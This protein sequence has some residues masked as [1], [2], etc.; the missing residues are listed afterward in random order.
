MKV[1]SRNCSHY[2]SI[3][4][5]HDKGKA[6]YKSS[7]SLNGILDLENEIKGYNWYNNFRSNEIDVSVELKTNHY[8]KIKIQY[9]DALVPSINKGYLKNIDYIELAIK[10]YVEIWSQLPSNFN[11]QPIHGDFSIEGNILFK[12]HNVYIIDWEHFSE[13]EASIGF[14][15]MYLLFETICI[16]RNCS[17]LVL[18]H[19][20]KMINFLKQNNCLDDVFTNNPLKSTIL[21]MKKN[22]HIWGEQFQKMPVLNFSKKSIEKIDAYLNKELSV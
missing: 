7:S 16:D 22:R 1:L 13:Q 18:N 21:F 14:D 17:K 8:I 19:V 4:V 12:D 20:V 10:H 6:I 2:S 15:A 5:V 3:F 11:T 9:I